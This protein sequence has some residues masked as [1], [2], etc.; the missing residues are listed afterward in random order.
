MS[1]PS[2][3]LCLLLVLGCCGLTWAAEP[4]L[5]DHSGFVT[6]LAGV[7]GT[8]TAQKLEGLCR[9]LAKQTGAE[10]AVATV[11]TVAP[12]DS[13]TYAGKLFEKWRIGKKGKD[14][15]VL[16]LLAMDERRVEIEVG[17]GLEGVIT[18]AGAGRI[19]DDYVVPFFKQGQFGEG[20][21]NGAAALAARIAKDAGQELGQ[22]YQAVPPA[23]RGAD[24]EG[25]PLVTGAIVILIILMVFAQGVVI[26][27]IGG[28]VGALVGFSVAGPAGAVIGAIIGFVV[29]YFRFPGSRW[30][31]G[32]WGGDIGGGWSG[33]GGGG[34]FGGGS[35]GGGGSGRSW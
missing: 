6:D 17:Y 9:Q 24:E 10:L 31:G 32:G 35:S 14:N 2:K 30:Y 27:L 29:S 22:D 3:Y 5:P 34:G 12:L 15:G 20:L 26:G 23:N 8:A 21:Y 33:G 4:P 16:L 7:I 19:L 1:R 28:V 13:K 11:K 18:D 25:N